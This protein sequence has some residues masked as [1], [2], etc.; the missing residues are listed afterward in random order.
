MSE[1]RTQT[2]EVPGA[3]LRYDIRDAEGEPFRVTLAI[4]ERFHREAKA[5]AERQMAFGPVPAKFA[6]GGK[7]G[8]RP[9]AAA[10]CEVGD[11]KP[12]LARAL[13]QAECRA[14]VVVTASGVDGLHQLHRVRIL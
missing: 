10:K 8:S 11:L 4:L 7:V 13:R 14:Q 6:S 12:P 9:T 2:L 3:R 1:P 5:A